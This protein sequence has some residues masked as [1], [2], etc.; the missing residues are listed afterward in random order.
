MVR[1]QEMRS[2]SGLAQGPPSGV[3][4]SLAEAGLLTV[5]SAPRRWL[6]RHRSASRLLSADGRT[7]AVDRGGH[8]LKWPGGLAPP[9]GASGVLGRR[10]PGRGGDRHG[11]GSAP[12]LPDRPGDL[13]SVSSV[14][15]T[16]RTSLWARHGGLRR[17]PVAA[18]RRRRPG[19]VQ[20]ADPHRHH[21]ADRSDRMP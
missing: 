15:G 8:G 12:A 20:A 3:S 7:A 11:R 9:V 21:Q 5:K 13:R 19:A 4:P 10:P 14:R 1:L 17:V 2:R 18:R 6:W 16:P